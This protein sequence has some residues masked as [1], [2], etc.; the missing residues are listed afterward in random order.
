M[1]LFDIAFDELI[2]IEGGY[3]NDPDD[4]GGETYKGISRKYWPDWAGWDIIDTARKYESNFPKCLD[5]NTVLHIL[6]KAFYEQEFWN[7]IKLD[8]IEKIDRLIALEMFD[9]AVNQGTKVSAMYLQESLNLLNRNQRDY[10]DLD[11]DGKIG[12]L[13]TLPALRANKS[14]YNVLKCLNGLQFDK[15]YRLAKNNPSQEKFFNGWL[16]RVWEDHI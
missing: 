14:K 11:I 6:V 1:R 4:R 2:G 8:E 13:E 5:E 9:T 15:Y 16:N 3:V 7:K 10:K 12:E